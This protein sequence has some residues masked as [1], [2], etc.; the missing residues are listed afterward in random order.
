MYWSVLL[1]EESNKFFSFLWLYDLE[2][3]KSNMVTTGVED[4]PTTYIYVLKSLLE[5]TFYF[6]FNKRID[7]FNGC[8]MRRKF[9]ISCYGY[10][11]WAGRLGFE[12]LQK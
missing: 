12:F 3:S 1:E 11:L 6:D 7:H 10:R 4:F 5:W 8:L 2:S 9:Q